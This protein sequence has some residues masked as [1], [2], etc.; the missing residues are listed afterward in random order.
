MNFVKCTKIGMRFC[1]CL[2]SIVRDP[3]LALTAA[4]IKGSPHL[5]FKN[6][7]KVYYSMYKMVRPGLIIAPVA[8]YRLRFWQCDAT[9]ATHIEFER[10]QLSRKSGFLAL[11]STS[12]CPKYIS[13]QW[14]NLISKN[15]HVW[16]KN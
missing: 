3:A 2:G 12:F 16:I 11:G 4:H 7:S 15:C 10:Q 9:N 14:P 6:K 13:I 5:H 8:F 1:I